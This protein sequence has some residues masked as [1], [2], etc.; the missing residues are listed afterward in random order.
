VLPQ[1][2][3]SGSIARLAE[4]VSALKPIAALLVASSASRHLVDLLVLAT[5][6]AEDL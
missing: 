5:D 4:Q 3:R 1:S 2:R 6:D